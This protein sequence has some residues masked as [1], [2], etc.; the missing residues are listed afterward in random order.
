M[1]AIQCFSD[2][3]SQDV[4][5]DVVLSAYGDDDVGKALGRLD[6]EFVHRLD[7]RAVDL[8]VALALV[9]SLKDI[10]IPDDVIA[11]GEIGLAGEIRS[12]SH[13]EKRI[14]EAARLGFKRC[15]LPYYNLKN[16]SK[17][18]D[19]DIELFGVRS[20]RQAVKTIMD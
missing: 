7:E 3:R 8:C 4:Y 12:V 18:I 13:V 10:A 5:A 20:I 14:K 2:F 17:D 15:I 9:S 1:T 6:E 16:L 11:F 19:S